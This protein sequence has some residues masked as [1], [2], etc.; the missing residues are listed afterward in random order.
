MT[1]S[2]SSRHDGLKDFVFRV[3][4][5]LR[6]PRDEGIM[7]F[8]RPVKCIV[9][10]TEHSLGLCVTFITPLPQHHEP[11]VVYALQ[12]YSN[13]SGDR[14]MPHVVCVAGDK[15]PIQVTALCQTH[16][17]T[18]YRLLGTHSFSFQSGYRHRCLNLGCPGPYVHG[19][20][21][22]ASG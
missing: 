5:H 14:C 2:R 3:S 7:S 20:P 15:T 6:Y 11:N 16:L 10:K 19:C 8:P 12:K 22:P 21:S 4:I 9:L 13:P 17:L 18:A 1:P